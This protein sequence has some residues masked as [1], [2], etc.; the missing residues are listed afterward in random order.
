MAVASRVRKLFQGVCASFVLV[1]RQGE[2][3]PSLKSLPN[4]DAKMHLVVVPPLYLAS[5]C[6]F[7]VLQEKL[8]RQLYAF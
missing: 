5:S 8:H 1:C 6:F 2:R 3:A 7:A 4:S